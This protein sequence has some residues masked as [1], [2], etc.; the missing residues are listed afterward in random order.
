MKQTLFLAGILI[1]VMSCR[2]YPREVEEVL[3]LSGD[4]RNELERV[5]N[6]FRQK[7]MQEFEAAC[8]LIA[9]IKKTYPHK[10]G[11]TEQGFIYTS[12]GVIIHPTFTDMG[13]VKYTYAQVAGHEFKEWYHSHP[14]GGATIPSL[15]D[16][17]ALSLRYQQGHIKSDDFTYGVVSYY[18]CLS[19]MISSPKDF[20]T[21]AEKVRNK[22]FDD[23]WN[24]DIDNGKSVSRFEIKIQQVMSFFTKH[25][26]GLSVM[27]RPMQDEHIDNNFE[28]WIAKDLNENNEL[29]DKDCK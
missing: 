24:R 29:I 3:A 17:K 4:N 19:I 18:G 1:I 14:G 7:D 10:A 2:P 12:K 6:H 15:G 25:K 11:N 8:F 27:F 21:F 16:L 20:T 28:N 9:N 23:E 13:S 26:A 5:L 22:E